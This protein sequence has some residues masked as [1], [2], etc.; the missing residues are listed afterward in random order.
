MK[1]R[2]LKVLFEIW[3]FIVFILSF[4]IGAIIIALPYYIITGKSF[5]DWVGEYEMREYKCEE[6]K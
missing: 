2:F 4:T 3:K 5:L 6:E 1:C